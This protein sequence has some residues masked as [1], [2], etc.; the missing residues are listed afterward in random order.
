MNRLSK[1]EPRRGVQDSVVAPRTPRKPLTTPERGK[2]HG[3][4]RHL[5]AS[6]LAVAVGATGFSLPNRAAARA[7]T[8]SS[9]SD[10]TRVKDLNNR[11]QQT[12]EASDFLG[13][14]DAWSQILEILPEN[15]TNREERETTLLVALDAY[16]RAATPGPGGP[17]E[18]LEQRVTTLRVG[19]A[20]FD[21]YE[22]EYQRVYGSGATVGLQAAETGAQIRAQYEE[23]RLLLKPEPDPVPDPDPEPD[24][25][26]I[27][28]IEKPFEDKP[29]GLGLIVGGSAVIVGGLGATSMIIVGATMT[30]RASR[31]SAKTMSDEE[32]AEVDRRGKTGEALIITGAVLGGLMLAGGATMLAFGVR[33]RIRYLAFSPSIGPAYVGAS[34]GGRF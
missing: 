29:S 15:R 16:M 20:T 32:Q 28:V 25:G 24:T 10:S 8:S 14:A 12:Y 13:A 30:K 19:V 31:D 33:R 34:V 5:V 18:G 11:A 4:H 21:T 3:L 23:A 22:K 26:T 17:K 7:P 2:A 6:A 1:S 9:M 27:T